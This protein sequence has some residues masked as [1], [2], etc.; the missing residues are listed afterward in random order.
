MD[1]DLPLTISEPADRKAYSTPAIVC[2]LKLET[3]AGS[4]FGT[5]VDPF[6]PLGID[7]TQPKMN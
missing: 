4:P 7:P 5:R 2:E 6:D 3:R 1:N